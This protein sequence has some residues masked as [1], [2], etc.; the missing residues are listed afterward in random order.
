MLRPTPM[1][2]S[3]KGG[4]IRT[5]NFG[6]KAFI[7]GSKS[8]DPDSEGFIGLQPENIIL[9]WECRRADDRVK[10]PVAP[11]EEEDREL[12]LKADNSDN[13]SENTALTRGGRQLIWHGLDYCFGI[14]YSFVTE[15][16]YSNEIS[17]KLVFDSTYMTPNT[18]Y[19]IRLTLNSKDGR[20]S[21][22]DQIFIAKTGQPARFVLSCNMNCRE[23]YIISRQGR[24]LINCVNC[25]EDREP[26]YSLINSHSLPGCVQLDTDLKI[27]N[28]PENCLEHN[29]KYKINLEVSL[30]QKDTVSD[31]INGKSISFKKTGVGQNLKTERVTSSDEINLVTVSKPHSGKCSIDFSGKFD[32]KKALKNEENFSFEEN[33]LDTELVSE[34]PS[35]FFQKE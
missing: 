15:K 25:E 17:S 6:S 33:V 16:G 14:D 23:N 5:V 4:K 29:K 27:I 26:L 30:I 18:P 20:K 7:D 3:L 13:N 19:Y 10:T 31:Q 35:Y 21:F 22:N 34:Y 2:T 8:F 1:I 11:S 9:Q 24:Y 12:S 32:L 28:I